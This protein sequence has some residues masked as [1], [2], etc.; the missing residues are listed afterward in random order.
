MEKEIIE[1]F[2]Y[3]F[4]LIGLI[5]E[6]IEDIKEKKI[7]L[8]VVF[9]ELPVIFGVRFWLG[10]A[11]AAMW[12]ASLGIGAFFY[13][14]SVLTKEQIGKGDA[15]VLCMTG[16]GIGLTNNLLLIYIT[17]LLAFFAAVFL[18]AIKRVHK[19]YSIPLTPFIL[20]SYL[21]VMG[22]KIL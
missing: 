14:L 1:K 8:A 6:T 17:F 5:V 16:A 9:V 15:F 2:M 3:C 4:L 13:L 12:I 10:N 20:C 11:G 18:R 7:Y 21:L 19:K 22:D